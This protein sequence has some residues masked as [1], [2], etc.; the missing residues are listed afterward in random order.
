MP[1]LEQLAGL[2]GI[3]SKPKPSFKNYRILY[4]EDNPTDR[5][6]IEKTL[7]KRDFQVTTATSAEEGWDVILREKPDLIL[8]DI[9]LPGMTGL[10]LCKKLKSD[11]AT[12]DIPIIFL[13][14]ADTPSNVVDCYHFGGEDFVNKKVSPRI[15]LSQIEYTLQEQSSAM[16]AEIDKGGRVKDLE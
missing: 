5:Y 14:G 2:F 9:I 4:V 12:K 1:I 8:L 13:T 10:E 15:L 6:L 3:K 7:A 16:G 11:P